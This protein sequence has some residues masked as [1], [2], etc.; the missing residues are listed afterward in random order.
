VKDSEWAM[1][2]YF[3]AEIE[4]YWVIDARDPDDIQFEI[5]KRGKKEFTAVKKVGGWVKSAVLSKSFRLAQSED[6]EGEPE[7]TF[8]YR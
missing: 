3:D 8:E 4:E 6:D 5:Y 7:F 1:S 2:A